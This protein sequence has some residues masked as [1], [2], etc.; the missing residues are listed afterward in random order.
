MRISSI[1]AL[2]VPAMLAV[3]LLH[4]DRLLPAATDG[5]LF[6]F[7]RATWRFA[8][9]FFFATSAYFFTLKLLKQEATFTVAARYVKRVLFIY[10]V[11]MLVYLMQ[12]IKW[13][14]MLFQVESP[15]A[16]Y[17]NAIALLRQI[18]AGLEPGILLNGGIYHLWFL[19]AL[20]VGLVVI[21]LARHWRA[22]KLLV[23]VAGLLYVAYLF[24]DV[25]YLSGYV[26]AIAACAFGWRLAARP[27]DGKNLAGWLLAGSLAVILIEVLYLK[28]G[29]NVFALTYGVG[30][31][32][33][34]ASLLLFA[35]SRPTFLSGTFLPRAG[36]L[37]LGIYV[38]HPLVD[39]AL[40]LAPARWEG[41]AGLL[42]F[43]LAVYTGALLLTALLARNALTRAWVS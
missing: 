10:L 8:V 23:P 15:Q 26:I 36:Q 41:L 27:L 39:Q 7:F 29:M 6:T 2:R 18:W 16:Y 14:A 13:F 40:T 9:P 28:D 43:P 38:A 1:D 12:P 21:A 3:V 31:V 20:A 5:E 4:T 34:A 19:P 25:P 17:W 32:M 24:L 30:P 33:L 42:L 37:T 35:I 11:W 22:E